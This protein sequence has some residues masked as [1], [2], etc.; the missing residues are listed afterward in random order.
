MVAYSPGNSVGSG[1]ILGNNDGMVTVDIDSLLP[2]ARVELKPIDNG[3]GQGESFG[4][5]S[6]FLLINA[7]SAAR[8]TSSRRSSTTRCATPT[9]TKPAR[10]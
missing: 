8:R 5:N 3:Q 7:E 9:A 6:D 10:P 4:D 1:Q 2:F